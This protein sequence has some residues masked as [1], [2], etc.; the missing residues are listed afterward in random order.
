MNPDLYAF[1][2]PAAI[3]A[4]VAGV[5]GGKYV[6]VPIAKYGI[7]RLSGKRNG[8]NGSAASGKHIALVVEDA[9]ISERVNGMEKWVKGIEDRQEEHREI[10]DKRFIEVTGALSAIQ[11]STEQHN[12]TLEKIERKLFNGSE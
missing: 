5:I 4:L 3:A 7:D 9:V 10:G 1:L 12:K 8:R 6:L 2:G 11:T